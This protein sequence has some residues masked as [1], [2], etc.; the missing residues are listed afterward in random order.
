MFSGLSSY[1]WGAAEDQVVPD[2]PL[3]VDEQ[4]TDEGWILVDLTSVEN[5]KGS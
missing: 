5:Q 3:E 1:I 4:K 2:C